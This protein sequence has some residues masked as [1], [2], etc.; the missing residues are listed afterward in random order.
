VTDLRETDAAVTSTTLAT[1][2][3]V[4]IVAHPGHELRVHGWLEQAHPLVCVLTD[5]SGHSMPS[6]LASTTEVLARVAAR[7]G[8]VYG[9]LTDRALYAAVLAGDATAFCALAEELADVLV[10]ERADYVVGDALEGYNP[11]HDL[12]RVLIDA[13]VALVAGHRH[14][15]RFDFPLVGPPDACPALLRRAA[16]T[17]RL[18]DAAF[19]RKLAAARAYPELADEVGSAI[20]SETEAAFRAECL[21]PLAAGVSRGVPLEDPPYYER[22]GEQQVQAGRYRDVLR[23]RVHVAPFVATLLRKLGLDR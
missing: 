5:G 12:C 8:P 22:Y 15:H 3:A 4:L 2:R 18:G 17:L 11:A 23:W 9:R 7:P 10:D 20:D 14:V 6:R 1:R 13:A 16:V 21:R 19:R